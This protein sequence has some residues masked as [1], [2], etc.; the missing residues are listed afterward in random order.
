MRGAGGVGDGPLGVFPAEQQSLDFRLMRIASAPLTAIRFLTVVPIPVPRVSMVGF[1]G[2]TVACFPLV[3]AAIGG[4]LA[5]VDW[6]LRLWLPLPLVAALLLAALLGVTGGLHL[7]GLMDSLDGLFGGG[8]PETRLEIMRDSRVGSYGIAGAASL[9]LVE[10]SCLV[11]LPMGGRVQALVLA[12]ALSRWAMVATL[13]GF[14]PASPKGL[15]AGL[16]PEVRRAHM[17]LATLFAM[18]IAGGSRGWVGLGMAVIAALSVLLG[19]R[20]AASRLGGVTGD[21]CGG[22]GQLVEAAVLVCAVASMA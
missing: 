19:G 7:D 18:G 15:A 20:L 13:W 2:W 21:V 9:L 1:M 8:S 16:K 12:M 10:Y 3:G 14:P 11:S 22:T 17:V 6:L 4:A 5:A